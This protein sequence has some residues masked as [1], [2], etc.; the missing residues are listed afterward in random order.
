MAI[1]AVSTA[2]L[3]EGTSVSEYVASAIEVLEEHPNV[4]YQ[5]GPMF[6]TLEGDLDEVLAVV[7]EMHESVF[8]GGALRVNTLIKID[9]RRDKDITVQGKL[10]AVNRR[11]R[12]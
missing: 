11:L 12:G 7:R 6:T 2:P 10:D 4:E 8:E 5:L 1:V 9:D 3:G